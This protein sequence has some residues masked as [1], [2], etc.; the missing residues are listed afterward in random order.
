M[1][2]RDKKAQLDAAINIR[3]L[4]LINEV[5]LEF[6]AG[7]NDIMPEVIEEHLKNFSPDELAEYDLKIGE[8][9]KYLAR[10][11]GKQLGSNRMTVARLYNG[12]GKACSVA[13]KC[14][15]ELKKSKRPSSKT[16]PVSA[17]PKKAARRTV[18]K[19]KKTEK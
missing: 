11:L 12:I 1:P 17:T 14:F 2:N 3:V 10:A 9:E 4:E 19:S 7:L 15:Q 5:Q 8:M 6:M 16:K 18:P 13:F